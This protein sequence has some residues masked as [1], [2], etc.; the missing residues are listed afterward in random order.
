MPAS[1][2]FL[3]TAGLT[4]LPESGSLPHLPKFG[5]L[6]HLSKFGIPP[7]CQSL[8]AYPTCQS[9]A[10]YPTCQSLAAYPTCQSLADFPTCQSLAAYSTQ[11]KA[12]PR[13]EDDTTATCSRQEHQSNEGTPKPPEKV[14]HKTKPNQAQ[15]DKNE[16]IL[17]LE[18]PTRNLCRWKTKKIHWKAHQQNINW[19]NVEKE[20]G[21]TKKSP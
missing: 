15:H 16:D 20:S 7:T 18:T 14:E 10:A 8:A 5:S 13:P 12:S 1:T 17:T 11:Y 3:L 2:T 4:H 6:S 9:L 19:K 21:K